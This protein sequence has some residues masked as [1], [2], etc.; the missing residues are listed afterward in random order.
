M[1]KIYALLLPFLLF[2]CDKKISENQN[3][4]KS[5]EE[6]CF[7]L[8]N[9]IN[10]DEP[11]KQVIAPTPAEILKNLPKHIK[12][13]DLEDFKKFSYEKKETAVLKAQEKK[14]FASAEYL[15]TFKTWISALPEFNYVS[16]EGN[17]ALA[18]NKYGLWIVEK[19][20]N[21]FKPYFLGLPQN[22]Y[23]EDFYGKNQKF[24]NENNFVMKGSL[25]DVQRLS[26]IP[27]LPKY[28]VI[29]EGVEFSINLDD[30]R[31]DSDQD[32]FNDL[33]EKFIG[34]NPNSADTDGDGIPDFKDPNPKYKSETSKFTVMYE[35][36]VDEPATNAN[37]SFTEILTNC[38][39]FLKINP[40]SKKVLMYTTSET[41]PIKEDVLDLFFPGKYS[42]MKTYP[43]Y[44]E[45]YFTDF[46][47]LTGDGTISAEYKNGKWKLDRKYTVT[48]GM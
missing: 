20:G 30:L 25:V 23:L 48:F 29:K 2:S 37:Y 47:D 7:I 35:M 41:A 1:I 33:F 18:K 26:R 4:T 38:D 10:Y 21:E 14:Y 19:I 8:S 17:F 6:N 16:Q 27:M 42:K 40:K 24:M 44:P 43:N 9:G 46:S 15:N 13:T 28:E 32:G 11:A 5:V 34:L 12:M 39:Y 45:V 3:S 22:V 31:K 36:M